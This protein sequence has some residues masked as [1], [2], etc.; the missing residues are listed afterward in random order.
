MTTSISRAASDTQRV[1]APRQAA[2]LLTSFAMV[3]AGLGVAAGLQLAT[4]ASGTVTGTVFED[5]DQDGTQDAREP[6]VADVVVTAVDADG[7]RSRDVRTDG[8]GT[9]EIDL[10]VVEGDAL[11]AGP[12]RIEFSGWPAHLEEGPVGR[13]SGSSIQFADADSIDVSLGL[14]APSDYC[15]DNP[16][17]VGTCFVYA[18]LDSPASWP[19]VVAVGWDWTDNNSTNTP[20]G[21]L[22]WIRDGAGQP[23]GETVLAT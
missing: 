6:G 13:D 19:T 7:N 14:A 20:N 23:I 8:E 15:Q 9:Y 12:Y 16:D 11:G 10:G 21:Q 2:S 4:A 18:G 22:D 17:V 5:Y 3:A 1:P